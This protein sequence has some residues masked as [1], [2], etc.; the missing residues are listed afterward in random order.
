VCTQVNNATDTEINAEINDAISELNDTTRDV[1]DDS[2]VD[3]ELASRIIDGAP[4]VCLELNE[5]SINWRYYTH[6]TAPT[7]ALHAQEAAM[8]AAAAR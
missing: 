6:Q 8:Q 1:V 5:K 7:K 4:L 2:Y 3:D